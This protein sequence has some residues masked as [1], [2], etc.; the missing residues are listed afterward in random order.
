MNRNDNNLAGARPI[1]ALLVHVVVV[2]ALMAGYIGAE[3]QGLVTPDSIGL[4]SGVLLALSAWMLISW[5]LAEGTLLNPY[6]L[7]LM[8]SLP[9]HVGF[10]LL[11]ILDQQGLIWL[12]GGVTEHRILETM[13]YVVACYTC[14]HLGAL[15]VSAAAQARPIRTV[16][17][18]DGT[19]IYQVGWLLLAISLIPLL[20][21]IRANVDVV[22][23]GGYSSLFEGGSR[24]PASG[25]AG[26]TA[27]IA[28]FY[29]PGV[30]FV[31]AGSRKRRV[32][33]VVSL[34]ALMLYTGSYLFMGY[35]AFSLIPV[36][37]F[38]WLWHRC[39]RPL[40]VL[41]VGLAGIGAFLLIAPLV[42][43]I[44]DMSGT[45]RLS[46]DAL[47]EAY[48]GAENPVLALLAELS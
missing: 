15:V 37:V 30:M 38:I 3:A 6:G 8:A 36:A 46:F 35:R 11:R 13:T 5:V 27:L 44:R 16:R 23:S 21:K 19:R 39:V 20:L 32:G 40:P 14:L 33:Q 28:Q 31:L 24:E 18:F 47:W 41:S 48:T 42:R 7:F 9:F 4:V 25:S 26:I 17:V 1:L 29:L 2:L 12:Q 34:L 22:M 45:D 43:Q 10:A